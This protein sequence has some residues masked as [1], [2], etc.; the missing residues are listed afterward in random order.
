[1]TC[2]LF[3][4]GSVSVLETTHF[5]IASMSSEYGSPDIVV[6]TGAKPL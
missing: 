1:M 3:Q 5:S 6:H 2:E 4:V